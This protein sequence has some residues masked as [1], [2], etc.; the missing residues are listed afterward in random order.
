M[1]EK[2]HGK[3]TTTD[4]A[5]KV[6]ELVDLVNELEQTSNGLRTKRFAVELEKKL[7]QRRGEAE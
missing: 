3:I 6:N 4:I 5:R 7:R 2:L 1:I